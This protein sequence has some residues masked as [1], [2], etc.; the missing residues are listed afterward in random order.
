DLPALS[1]PAADPAAVPPLT[2]TEMWSST[3]DVAHSMNNLLGVILNLC[4]L[5]TRS[6]TD[7]AVIADLAEVRK[8]T[9]QAVDL[10]KQMPSRG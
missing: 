1:E 9:E 2:D 10:V 4:A 8:A 3:T 6:A 7:P 5:L